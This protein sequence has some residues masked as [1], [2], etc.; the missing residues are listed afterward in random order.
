MLG[1]LTPSIMVKFTPK[2]GIC[3]SL[4]LFLTFCN[5]C[6][7]VESKFFLH[8]VGLTHEYRFPLYDAPFPIEMHIHNDY[9]I[10]CQSNF[11]GSPPDVFFQAYS[12]SDHS[13]RGSFGHKGRGPGEWINPRIISS[14]ANSPYLYL[15]EVSSRQNSAIIHKMILDTTI[16]LQ[17]VG[18]FSIEKG[19]SAMNHPVI[20]NDSLLVFDE[21]MPEPSIRVH[22][23]KEEHPIVS[24]KYGA[25]SSLDNRFADKNLGTLYANDSSILFL[26][27]LKNRIDFM[28]WNLEPI[29]RLNYQKDKPIIR[30][31]PRD[32]VMYYGR[33][34]L[35]QYFLYARFSG[36]ST[37]EYEANDYK[38]QVLE[39]FDLKGTPVCCYTFS[40][41]FPQAFAVDERTFTLY[42]YW[43]D[44]GL[45]DSISVYR[46]PGLK[47]YLQEK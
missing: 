3:F 36:V 35:G 28:N 19:Y 6:D 23:L 13:Y 33:S 26:Y 12:L 14:S 16:Q 44:S 32:N 22:H 17:E 10:L 20:R 37:R 41:A 21:F 38:G 18:S 29:K 15:F 30:N 11:Q 45:E 24:W 43:S 7:Q 25:S 40:E 2:R 1:R 5:G 39:V 31:D 8:E 34:Y 42:G 46:L 47:E 4:F 9:L 27:T